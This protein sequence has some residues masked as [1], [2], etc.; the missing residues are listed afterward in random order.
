DLLTSSQA[1]AA[2][3]CPHAEEPRLRGVSKHEG[4]LAFLPD[5][6]LAPLVPSPLAGE[7]AMVCPPTRMGEGLAQGTFHPL[8][9]VAASSRPLPQPKS[10]SSD[11]GQPLNR[12]NSGKPEFGWERAQ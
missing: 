1:S 12:P 11:F 3:P 8:H 10:V 6:W 2:L 5:A 7:G 9:C 4:A